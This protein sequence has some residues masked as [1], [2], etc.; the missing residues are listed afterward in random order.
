M[1]QNQPLH[2]S[3]AVSEVGRTRHTPSDF[4]AGCL[5]SVKLFRRSTGI[6]VGLRKSL[7]ALSFLT[8]AN[9]ITELLRFG[10]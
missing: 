4:Q 2:T 8:P 3:F 5:A 10:I 7:S 1:E 9:I 6:V